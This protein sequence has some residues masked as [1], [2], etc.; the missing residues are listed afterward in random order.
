M[1]RCQELGTPLP[2]RCVA[3]ALSPFTA[4]LLWEGDNSIGKAQR[5]VEEGEMEDKVEG[6]LGTTWGTT[7]AASRA[8]R[9]RELMNKK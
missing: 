9:L 2:S 1:A 7:G 6:P 8:R 4:G 3:V 5:S